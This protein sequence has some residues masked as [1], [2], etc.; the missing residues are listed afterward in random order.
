M[1]MVYRPR[2]ISFHRIEAVGGWT[3]KMYGIAAHTKAPR[4]AL[5]TATTKIAASALPQ[6]AE[7]PSAGGRRCGA[8]SR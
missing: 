6:Q 1:S 7:P 8:A 5:M 4:T 3:V 2:T